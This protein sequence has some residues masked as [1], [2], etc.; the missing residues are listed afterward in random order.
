MG[1]NIENFI[2]L[3]RI[4]SLMANNKMPITINSITNETVKIQQRNTISPPSSESI[5]NNLYS[6][7]TSF[8]VEI[9][10]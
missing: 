10:I 8:K 6:L 5:E 3:C 1:S 7:Q 2:E 9:K 4:K